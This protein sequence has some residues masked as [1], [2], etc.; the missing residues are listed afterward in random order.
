MPAGGARK[1][2]DGVQLQKFDS[3]VSLKRP[4]GSDITP[5][6]LYNSLR[7]T[8]NGYFTQEEATGG[9]V[10]SHFISLS[11]AEGP[12]IAGAACCPYLLVIKGHPFSR[13][14]L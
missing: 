4:D 10:D 9:N 3:L 2:L 7:D 6:S 12:S 13:T 5:A 1:L 14:L 11:P 8:F